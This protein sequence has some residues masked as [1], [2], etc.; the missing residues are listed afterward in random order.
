MNK[1]STPI[2]IIAI[3]NFIAAALTLLFWALALIKLPFPFSIVNLAERANLATT[4]G[5]GI[6]DIIFSLPLLFFGAIG[7]WR[8]KFWGWFM[9]QLTNILWLYSLTVIICRDLFTQTI[10]PGT[11]IF[12]PFALF[13]I[14]AA[15][16]LWQ[17][18]QKFLA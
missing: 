2:K 9:I 11:I 6:A 3:V 16:W 1:L 8:Q 7:I 10:S 4:Y 17:N 14:W 12:L 18:K 13:A 15:A 5:F